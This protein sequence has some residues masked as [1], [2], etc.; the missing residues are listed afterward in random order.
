MWLATCKKDQDDLQVEVQ[1]II[2]NADRGIFKN[3]HLGLLS[4]NPQP[5]SFTRWLVDEEWGKVEMVFKQ[6]TND[7]TRVFGNDSLIIIVQRLNLAG[8]MESWR[9]GKYKEAKNIRLELVV[10]CDTLQEMNK[11]CKASFP[12]SKHKERHFEIF[13]TYLQERRYS[14]PQLNI[15][16]PNSKTGI[17][18]HC[19]ELQSVEVALA[20]SAN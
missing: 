7:L 19:D 20:E 3:G 2:K 9:I 12:W 13:K 6:E 17:F 11:I 16:T 1:A 10:L 4:S 15:Q 5:A 14:E 8:L 18:H